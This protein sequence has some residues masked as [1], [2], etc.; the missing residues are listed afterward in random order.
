MQKNRYLILNN[1][2]NTYVF[3]RNPIDPYKTK[4]TNSININRSI[5]EESK[6]LRI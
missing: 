3:Q 6:N 2:L 5:S 1:D 4:L